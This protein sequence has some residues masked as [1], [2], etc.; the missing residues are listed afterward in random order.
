[1]SKASQAK[2]LLEYLQTHDKVTQLD[3]LSALGIMRLGARVWDLKK[4]GY[5][6]RTDKVKV[7][8]R[9]GSAIVAGYTLVSAEEVAG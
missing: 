4:A 6:I 5:E 8:T 9:D 1:M 3:A 2:A 7:P